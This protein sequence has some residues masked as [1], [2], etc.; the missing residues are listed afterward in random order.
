[1]SDISNLLLVVHMTAVNPGTSSHL[2]KLVATLWCLIWF[3][4]NALWIINL[5][6]KKIVPTRSLHHPKSEYGVINCIFFYGSS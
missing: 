2:N 6:K 1:M 4:I 3:V 5:R